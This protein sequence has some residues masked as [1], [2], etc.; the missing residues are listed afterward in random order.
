MA[1]GPS[2]VV[3]RCERAARRKEHA[4]AEAVGA[5]ALSASP[6]ATLAFPVSDPRRTVWL[7]NAT[8]AQPEF[9]D[10]PAE[11][12]LTLE[13][14]DSRLAPKSASLTPSS[15]PLPTQPRRDV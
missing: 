12:L 14:W 5:E 9:E 15:L 3:N 6:L 2:R 4:R 13:L 8:G 7:G 1:F 10:E 11:R